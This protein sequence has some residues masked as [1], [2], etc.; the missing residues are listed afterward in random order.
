MPSY[1]IHFSMLDVSPADEEFLQTILPE[2][3]LSST[4]VGSNNIKYR[5]PASFYH[6]SAFPTKEHALD[7]TKRIALRM[8]KQCQ[9]V[10]VEGE[11]LTWVGLDMIGRESPKGAAKK[12]KMPLPMLEAEEAD[13]SIHTA[14]L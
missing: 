2:A 6:S 10:I 3:G 7:C 14:K 12:R 9:I 11:T 13:T 5:L 8:R 1:L 4:I